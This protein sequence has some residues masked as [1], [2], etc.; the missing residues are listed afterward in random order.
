MPSIC[1]EKESGVAIGH[2]TIAAFD[3]STLFLD[4]CV[5]NAAILTNLICEYCFD[6]AYSFARVAVMHLVAAYA[7]CTVVE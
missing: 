6:K 3:T 5:C 4:S 7:L 2:H 1:T